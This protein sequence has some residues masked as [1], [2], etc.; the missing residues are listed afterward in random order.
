MN[1]SL[2]GDDADQPRLRL[3]RPPAPAIVWPVGFE[4][5]NHKDPQLPLDH[6]KLPKLF[7]YMTLLLAAGTVSTYGVSAV[8]GLTDSDAA[9]AMH[10]DEALIA[11]LRDMGH[12]T[13]VYESAFERTNEETGEEERVYV[14]SR[15]AG[16]VNAKHHWGEQCRRFPDGPAV[17]RWNRPTRR[18]P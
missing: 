5:R 8:G 6:P 10:V 9:A 3:V 11:D 12:V 18:N 7:D 1:A 17:Y 4:G 2:F 16:T 15:N 13:Y 14:H